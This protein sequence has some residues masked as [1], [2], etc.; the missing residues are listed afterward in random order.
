MTSAGISVVVCSYNGAARIAHCL[1][2]LCAQ[3]GE[4]HVEVIVV[5]DGSSD[6]TSAVARRFPVQV[7]TLPANQG[8][9]SARNAGIAAC[10]HEMVAF[11]DDDCVP[12]E[13]WT[14]SLLDV[15]ARAPHGTVGVGGHV[16]VH[17]A[18]T[19]NRRYLSHNNP[20]APLELDTTAS[21]GI[22]A[23]FL[24]YFAHR[25]A[26]TLPRFVGSMVGANMSYSKSALNDVGGFDDVITFGGDEE[27]LARRLRRRFGEHSLFVDP[28]I[29]MPHEFE[30]GLTDTLRRARAYGRG[31]GREFARNGGIPAVRPT[32]LMSLLG[33]VVLAPVSFKWAFVVALTTPLLVFRR[34]LLKAV[35]QHNIAMALYPAVATAQEIAC[36]VGVVEGWLKHRGGTRS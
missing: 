1:T 11:T 32:P 14:A 26:P 8:L 16:V 33:F 22:V 24:A 6:T 17:S 36:N 5:D 23:R 27:D 12:S 20:L 7:I 34:W 9:S 18:D 25:D 13:N 35:R 28:N 3:R 4:H 29:E 31:T 15:W 2:T 30:P 19:F 21:R 10:S